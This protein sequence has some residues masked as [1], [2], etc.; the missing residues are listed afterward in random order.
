MDVAYLDIAKAFDSVSHPKLIEKLQNY[1]FSGQ[2]LAWIVDFLSNR[3]Q[4]VKVQTTTSNV[5]PVTSGVPQGSVLG[6]LLF[7]LYINDLPEV[8]VNSNIFLFADD[9]K[10]S[11]SVNTQAQQNIFTTDLV[12]IFNW[13]SKHQLQISLPKC[14]ILHLGY[15]NAK[16]DYTVNGTPLE[17]VCSARDLGIIV[18]SNLTFTE[19]CQIISRKAHMRANL[20]HRCFQTKDPTF[21]TK[22]FKTYV[23]PI[24]EYGSVIWSP[25]LQKNIKI[26]EQVQRRFTK[27]IPGLQDY[28]YQQRLDTLGLESLEIRRLQS[29]LIMLYKIIHNL[30]DLPFEQLFSWRCTNRLLRNSQRS[31]QLKMDFSRTTVRSNFFSN[32]V[33]KLWNSLDQNLVSQTNLKAFISEIENVDLDALNRAHF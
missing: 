27:R 5:A 3:T 16:L 32:R 6:P 8:V 13:A 4:I 25:K 30:L 33:I 22:L 18:S 17:S 1:G 28:T 26:I 7:L 24:V 2:L 31:F 23:R 20:I 14:S 15:T 29:D 21:L 12:N 9:A 19:H 10:I 11:F